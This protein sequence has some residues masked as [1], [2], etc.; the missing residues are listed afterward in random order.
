MKH[1]SGFKFE[2]KMASTRNG[3]EGG[4]QLRTSPSQRFLERPLR[5]LLT[6]WPAAA[7]FLGTWVLLLAG[8]QA[9]T[10]SC[11]KKLLAGVDWLLSLPSRCHSPRVARPM[12]SLAESFCSVSSASN[13]NPHAQA[14]CCRV[15]PPSADCFCSSKLRHLHL[16]SPQDVLLHLYVLLRLNAGGG[17]VLLR[18]YAKFYYSCMSA[19]MKILLQM[20]AKLYYSYTPVWLQDMCVCARACRIDGR[21]LA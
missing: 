21:V 3:A 5:N 17:E 15:S 4:S 11:R 6:I 13:L 2:K 12:R 7:T 8:K 20:Y 10:S 14:F 18:L 1:F 16:L 9:A 19:T